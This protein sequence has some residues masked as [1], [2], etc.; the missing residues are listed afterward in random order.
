MVC[1][2]PFSFPE[3]FFQHLICLPVGE[4]QPF[5]KVPT[6]WRIGSSNR[7]FYRISVTNSLQFQVLGVFV[8]IVYTSKGNCKYCVKSSLL[9]RTE[10]CNSKGLKHLLC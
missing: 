8:Y 1:A 10:I 4:Q 2:S 3:S 5:A 7:R 9:C 6:Y